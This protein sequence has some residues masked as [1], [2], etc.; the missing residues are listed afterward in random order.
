MDSTDA[1]YWQTPAL[2]G[3]TNPHDFLAV[4]RATFDRLYAEGAHHPRM[5]SAGLH[6]RISGRPS[7][8]RQIERFIAYA[9]A[10]PGVWFARRADIARWW[11]EHGPGR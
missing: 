4:L 9:R 8:A 3:F 6:L 11:L 1:R 10:F 7:R 2:A 5:M